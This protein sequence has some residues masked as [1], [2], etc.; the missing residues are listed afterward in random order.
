[1]L[2][3]LFLLRPPYFLEF[4]F[5]PQPF[6]CLHD[7]GDLVEERTQGSGAAFLPLFVS[8][9]QCLVLLRPAHL[10][11]FLIPPPQ[12]VLCLYNHGDLVEEA[13]PKR[14]ECLALARQRQS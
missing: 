8:I 4:F 7:H 12:L 11:S 14:A 10:S 3:R 6:L 9:P 2:R 13:G 1:M 5:T